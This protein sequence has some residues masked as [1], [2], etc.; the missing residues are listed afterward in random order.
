MAKKPTI[1]TVS[2]GYQS[3]T[4][5][6]DNFQNLRNAFDNT[7]SLDGSTPNAMQADLDM[8]SNDILNANL[9]TTN[10]ISVDGLNLNDIFS[11]IAADAAS[12]ESSKNAAAASEAA[13]ASSAASAA[14][15]ATSASNNALLAVNSAEA[16]AALA[17]VT[18]TF[19]TKAAM[20]SGVGGIA[21]NAYV[22]V[23]TDET[24]GDLPTVWRKIAGVMTYIRTVPP[25]YSTTFANR[26]DPQWFVGL[27]PIVI[28]D[29]RNG[30]VACYSDGTVWRRVTDRCPAQSAIINYYIDSVS[31]VDTNNGT[32]SGSAIKTISKLISL[33]GS[34]SA[35]QNAG[36]HFA[37]KYGST[38]RE[39]FV[40][41]ASMAGARCSAY[42]V[43]S[44]GKPKFIASDVLTNASFTL[45]SGRTNVYEYA[46]TGVGTDSLAAEIPGVWVDNQR[47]TYVASVA[48]CDAKPGT[49]YHGT[50]TNATSFTLYVH[51]YGSTNPTTDSKVYEA[52]KRRSGVWA[53]DAD[54]C[55]FENIFSSRNHCSYGSLCLGRNSIARNCE[56]WDGNS[57][58][59]FY[60]AGCNLYDNIAINGYVGTD[61]PTLYIG[62]EPTIPVGSKMRLERCVAEQLENVSVAITNVTGITQANPAVVTAVAHGLSSNDLV[63][64]RD[65]GGM[66]SVNNV[67]FQITVLSVDTFSLRTI[68]LQTGSVSNLNSTALSAY[69][70]GGTVR[71]APPAPGIGFYVHG[72]GL[73]E[74][75]E[76]IDCRVF[77]LGLA[78]SGADTASSIILR[79]TVRQ[80]TTGWKFKGRLF[81]TGGRQRDFINCPAIPSSQI[82]TMD[83]IGSEMFMDNIEALINSSGQIQS[84]FASTNVKITNCRLLGFN[85]FIVGSAAN[86]RW[87]IRGN[88]FVPLT[89]GSTFFN[90]SSTG[91]VVSSD[92]NSFGLTD[93]SSDF[94]LNGTT[95]NSITDWRLATGND[96]NSEYGLYSTT[97]RLQLSTSSTLTIA[98][99]VVSGALGSVHAID[100]EALAATDDLDT[101]SAT[102]A[103]DGQMLVIFAANGGRTIVA[104]NATGNL[105]LNSDFSMDSTLDRL[106]LIYSAGIAAWVETSRSNN[107]T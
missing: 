101:I 30:Q 107:G 41:T 14:S 106:V 31:G 103:R 28:T 66:T 44:D 56:Q 17:G 83:E 102:S 1:T 2:S 59:I 36:L 40:I 74:S 100:T 72:T 89:R 55:E 75:V 97:E 62:F 81:V 51:P 64:L 61:T 6:N 45:S 20:D 60:R 16:A 22:L 71:R 46:M 8:N 13:S 104:K 24:H 21:A 79:P 90:F 7:L 42:G 54:G 63:I 9:I 10:E 49:F 5:I 3:T 65:V 50:V 43:I 73:H 96:T 26:P 77:G 18:S 87:T 82:S 70:S 11:D 27:P 99:G 92:L 67:I 19:T 52:T 68:D 48:A 23:L 38:F 94:I 85:T 25:S 78:F 76:Y 47:L 12:A 98:S 39:E 34:L 91:A 80:C 4:T 84:T 37:F 105:Y 93:G 35:Y 88:E 69:T 58:N 53:Y 86:Q 95:Y 57:H 33:L 15:S 32:T 29:E